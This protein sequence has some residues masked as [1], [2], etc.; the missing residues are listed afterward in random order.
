MKVLR[1][2]NRAEL[3]RRLSALSTPFRISW[4]SPAETRDGEVAITAYPAWSTGVPVLVVGVACS[5]R[6]LAALREEG[7]EWTLRRAGMDSV[8]AEGRVVGRLSVEVFGLSNGEYDLAIRVPCQAKPAYAWTVPLRR[9]AAQS[10][11]DDSFPL[12]LYDVVAEFNSVPA[13]ENEGTLAAQLRRSTNNIMT[14]WVRTIGLSLAG[15]LARFTFNEAQGEAPW[16]VIG[17]VGMNEEGEGEISLRAFDYRLQAMLVPDTHL[18]LELVWPIELSP[19]DKTVLELSRDAAI[20]GRDSLEA[21]LNELD[22]GEEDY[23]GQ[24]GPG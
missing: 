23:L 7:Y 19:S 11:Q 5:L 9:L 12:P 17:F 8:V 3:G 10:R 4:P 20:L 22:D 24:K 1:R 18:F 14:L 13:G 21:A 6:L 16:T 2:K 15:C